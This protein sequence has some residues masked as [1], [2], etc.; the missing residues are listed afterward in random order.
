M[1]IMQR[2]IGVLMI[3]RVIGL[4][5]VL[6]AIFFVIQTILG[7][8][9]TLTEDRRAALDNHLVI[10]EDNTNQLAGW[11]GETE[12]DL[13]ETLASSFGLLANTLSQLDF[14]NLPLPSY[15]VPES[16]SLIVVGRVPVAFQSFA[17]FIADYTTIDVPF[18]T[19]IN[20]I[21]QKIK[22]TISTLKAPLEQL[23]ETS[24][25]MNDTLDE[26]QLA[27]REFNL[28]LV[29]IDAFFNGTR[30]VMQNGKPVEVPSTN[31]LGILRIL[32]TLLGILLLIWYITSAYHDFATGWR[33][34][35]GESV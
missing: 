20:K 28:M 5:L 22:D 25:L 12:D 19:D 34:L 7:Q 33:L 9:A 27:R 10:I 14:E 26:M 30:I 23:A 35:R 15:T 1:Y 32:F 11:V 17:E 6:I 8:L 31:W 24:A 3:A 29:D 18:A 13:Q 16:L 4:T 21:P 2:L